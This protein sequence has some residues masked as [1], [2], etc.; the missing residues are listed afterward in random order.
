METITSEMELSRAGFYWR[1]LD[2]V[3]ALICAPLE[4][5]GFANGFSTRVG[6]TSAMPENAL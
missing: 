5:A 3:R 4:E 1:E 6:G 2:G